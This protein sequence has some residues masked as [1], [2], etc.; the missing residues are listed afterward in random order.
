MCVCERE[1]EREIERM[2]GGGRQEERGTGK[3]GNVMNA[4]SVKLIGSQFPL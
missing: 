2:T 3:R 4:M 1:G